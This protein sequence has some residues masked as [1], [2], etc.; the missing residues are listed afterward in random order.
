MILMNYI[1]DLN[2]GLK[3]LQN[4]GSF[5]SFFFFFLALE[6]CRKVQ[7][8]KFNVSFKIIDFNS[9]FNKYLI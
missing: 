9:V 7:L 3:L 1:N 8:F 4:I 6:C 2:D 5:L